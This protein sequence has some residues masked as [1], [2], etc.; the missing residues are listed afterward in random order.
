V[1]DSAMLDKYCRY[2][3]TILIAGDPGLGRCSD[4]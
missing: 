1:T 2:P 4:D 3:V